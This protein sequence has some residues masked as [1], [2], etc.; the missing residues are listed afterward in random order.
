MADEARA[1][2]DALMGADRDA[3]V[4]GASGVSSHQGGGGGPTRRQKRLSSQE[5]PPGRSLSPP[6]RAPGK[7]TFTISSQ[8]P[9]RTLVPIPTV[10]MI[11]R[12]RNSRRCPT[13]K[14]AVWGTRTC[15]PG[16]YQI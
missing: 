5:T 1:M 6:M 7:L 11:T 13:M 4:E 12:G 16:S 10:S 15:S 3:P 14:N 8:I 9:S 2:L